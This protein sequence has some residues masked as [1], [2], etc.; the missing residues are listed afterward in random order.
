MCDANALFYISIKLAGQ[1]RAETERA[2]R[3]SA[4]KAGC[5]EDK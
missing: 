1:T 3:P 2:A 4:V 5:P